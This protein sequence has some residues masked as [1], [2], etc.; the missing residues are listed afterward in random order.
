[1]PRARYGRTVDEAS[2][3]TRLALNLSRIEIAEIARGDVVSAIPELPRS[4]R[5]DLVLR[6]LPAAA[7][8]LKDGSPV[9]LHLGTTRVAGHIVRLGEDLFQVMVE[10]PLPAEG[11]VGVILR[12][13]SA[14]REHGR[15]LGGG[16]I[17]DALA[18]RIPKRRDQA[19][20]QRRAEILVRIRVGDLEA[21]LPL[22]IELAPRPIRAADIERRLGLEPAGV[23][24]ALSETAVALGDA[25]SFTSESALAAVTTK[26]MR[27]R[28]ALS[29]RA[30]ARTRCVERN[31]AYPAGRSRRA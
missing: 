28:G 11:G 21:A 22:M 31:G 20:W 8:A 16:R 13:F 9:I 30:S 15:V 14:S 26:L 7:R 25:R 19:A 10:R 12:G 18:A 6:T 1:M 27:L 3:P 5:M 24:R 17:L 29:H 4:E 23:S 2:A